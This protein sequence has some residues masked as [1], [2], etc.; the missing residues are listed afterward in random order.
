MKKSSNIKKQYPESLEA[1]KAVLGC[2]LIDP[3]AIPRAVNI[4][5]KDSFFSIENCTW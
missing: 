3:D 4:L 5:T 2:M 1:E